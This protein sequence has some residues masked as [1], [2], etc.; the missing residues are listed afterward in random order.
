M[1]F[2]V[3]AIASA[4]NQFYESASLHKIQ[5][6]LRLNYDV[7]PDPSNVYRWVVK[8][9]QIAVRLM[10]D[11]PVMVGD[12]WVADETVLKLKSGSERGKGENWKG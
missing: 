5:R 6:Q 9:T 11:V 10:E 1:R 3:D 8:Y 2:P 7:A 4:L 12:E